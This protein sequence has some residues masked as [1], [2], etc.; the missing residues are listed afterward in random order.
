[1]DQGLELSVWLGIA[2][3]ALGSAHILLWRTRRLLSRSGQDVR[4]P[5]VGLA[6]AAA[7]EQVRLAPAPVTQDVRLVPAAVNH[8]AASVI[9]S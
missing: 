9:A 7:K 4:A 6:P 8:S 1:M 3:L 5:E 2:G